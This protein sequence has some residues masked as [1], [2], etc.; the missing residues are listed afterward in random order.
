MCNLSRAALS[1]A[2]LAISLSFSGNVSVIG[3]SAFL[4]LN[5]SFSRASAMLR[6]RDSVLLDLTMSQP[7]LERSRCSWMAA[8][9][10]GD[11]H[12][13]EST[14]NLREWIRNLF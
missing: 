4:M 6:V 1:F 11:S 9:V 8:L 10:S 13:A 5:L 3:F 2:F 12:E 7:S 14:W